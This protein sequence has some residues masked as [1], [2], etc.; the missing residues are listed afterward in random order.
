MVTKAKPIIAENSV[1]GDCTVFKKT[2]AAVKKAESAVLKITAWG[3][4]EARLNGN[5]VGDFVLA[6]GW[7]VYEK[8]L[9]MQTYDITSLL[10]EEN[11]LEVTVGG[12][13][14]AGRITG[15]EDSWHQ[16][17]PESENRRAAL[18]AEI[19]ITYTD[20][21][22]DVIPTDSTWQTGRGGLIFSDI[23]DG[24]VYDATRP[25]V[26]DGTA[27]ED[28][29]L[30][31]SVVIPTVGEAVTEHERL[32]G[33]RL[34]VTPR[35]EKVIDFGQ[36]TAGYPEI[37]V[38][39]KAGD[40]V[41]LSFAEILD[42]DG[43]FY[44]EN[45]RSAKCRYEYI[46][47]DGV[48]TFKPT[49][50]FYGYRY[51]RIDEYPT[52]NPDPKNFT[53]VVLHSDIR[54]TG[55]F[56]S[57]DPLLNRLY[58]NIIWG[59]KGN[60]VDVPTDCPQRDERF[61]YTGDAQVF[62]QTA[63]L[64]FDVRRFFEK[65]LGDLAL[66]QPENGEIPAI[67]PAVYGCHVVSGGWGDAVT[68]CPW[69]MYLTYGD[70]EILERMYPK[71]EKW[72]EYIAASSNDEYLWTGH[73]QYGDW[74]ELNPEGSHTDKDLIGSAF[75]AHSCMLTYKAGKAIGADCEKY[76]N[77]YNRIKEEYNK[78]YGDRLKTQTELVLTVHFGLTDSPEELVARLCDKIDED[79]G[80]LTTGFLGTPYLLHVL[81]EYSHAEK[82]YDLLL[83][84]E[85]PSWLYPVTCGA[86]TMWE[87]WDGI[88][89]DGTVWSAG[90]NS[91][92]HYAYGAVGDWL[93]GKAAGINRVEAHPGFERVLFTPHAT[94]KI[95][96]L[97]ARIETKYG[98]VSSKWENT[99]NGVVYEMI[100]PVPAEA[101]IGGKKY[102]LNI[103]KNIIKI[104][105]SEEE[106]AL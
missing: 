8:R 42:K 86:T 22:A 100:S 82:A 55:F 4:Y 10:R 97:S 58:E 105:K 71:M 88:R 43:N 61:G 90:M 13:W 77:L 74:L 94:E 87:H 17:D 102:D 98:T 52:Q 31:V 2:F 83:R 49:F 57:S 91:Y 23:Y 45:Y 29:E 60:F 92:N 30:D 7:T 14:Y 34:I 15:G 106:T 93:Y 81:T 63:C 64:N 59:Q 47:R 12:G 78:K 27:A 1:H 39:A 103:G 26:F 99:E 18:L 62:M 66:L 76:K 48:Q 36:N 28:A 32:V 24:E 96:R 11:T 101:V 85:Y 73:F 19:E 70:R 35:G 6:P 56:E 37:T 25:L 54:R 51:V 21:K 5:R 104:N 80:H 65:W 50:T 3:V 33:Q 38:T 41:R 95:E 67:A 89:P 69:E 20:G 46:C 75:Y 16:A 68:I 44:N 9:Q 79:G 84:R 72:L 53:A 40:R